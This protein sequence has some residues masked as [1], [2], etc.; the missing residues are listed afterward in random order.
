MAD[1]RIYIKRSAKGTDV[2]VNAD[3]ELGELAINTY[4]GKLYA[5]KDDGSASIIEI[6]AK[7]TTGDKGQKGE[8]SPG[9]Q[10]PTG[11]DGPQGPQGVAG[12]KVA[13]GAAGPTGSVGP[14]GHQGG[15]G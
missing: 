15:K 7:G 5:K 13:T 11:A 8:L 3:L 4:D 6:G 9:P 14:T 10:G 1:N 2:P 12:D